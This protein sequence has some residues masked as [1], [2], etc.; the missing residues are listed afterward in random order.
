MKLKKVGAICNAGGC[1]YLMDERD[2]A[3]EVVGQ[4]LGDG[5]SAYPMVGLPVMDLENICAM[6]DITEKKREKLVMRRADVPDS[7]NW[8]DMAPL[9]RQLDDPKLCVRYDGRDLLPLETTAGVTF[10]QEKYLLPLDGLEYMRLYERQSASGGLYIVVKI[11][12]ILQAVIMP[13]DLP[14]KDFMEALNGLTSQCRD[15]TRKKALIP[16]QESVPER[17]TGPL[18]QVDESTGEVVGEGAEE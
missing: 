14:D 5:R 6:F 13:M 17:E 8:E 2:A 18:F 3:G 7:M 11:G 9:E 1:Y 15:A 4:W 12:M 16:K 10:I